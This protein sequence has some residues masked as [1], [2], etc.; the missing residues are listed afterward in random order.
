MVWTCDLHEFALFVIVLRP[1]VVVKGR[2][3]QLI[4]V[5]DAD[6]QILIDASLR[7]RAVEEVHVRVLSPATIVDPQLSV[8]WR[9]DRHVLSYAHDLGVG[10]HFRVGQRLFTFP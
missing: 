3:N 8:D 9:P 6:G 2:T 4:G 7:L 5:Y 1:N 10:E